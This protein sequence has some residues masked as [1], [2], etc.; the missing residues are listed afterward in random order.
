MEDEKTQGESPMHT[1]HAAPSPF[2]GRLRTAIHAVNAIAAYVAGRRFTPLW[3][4][5][6]HRGR[7]S[8]R[9]YT[10]PVV[11]RPVDGGFVLPLAWGPTAEWCRDV[12]VA[13]RPR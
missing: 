10:T 12:L 8:G 1:A 3:G 9:V 6:R 13:G 5:M 11:L 7:R 2:A 4:L